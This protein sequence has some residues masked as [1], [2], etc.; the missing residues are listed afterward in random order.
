MCRH[1]QAEMRAMWECTCGQC[2]WAC[3]VWMAP[4][5]VC[6]GLNEQAWTL[7]CVGSMGGDASQSVRSLGGQLKALGAG[8]VGVPACHAAVHVHVHSCHAAVSVHMCLGMYMP[9]GCVHMCAC[10]KGYDVAAQ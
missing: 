9:C 4:N 7:T 10:G 5:G 3:A 6:P 8:H 1:A 2:M